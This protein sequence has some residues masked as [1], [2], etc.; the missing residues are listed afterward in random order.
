MYT[1]SKISLCA[2][3]LILTGC[4][5]STDTAAVTP[6]PP[7]TPKAFASFVDRTAGLG[8]LSDG[9]MSF[10]DATGKFEFAIGRATTFFIGT[11]DKR[12]ELG[13]AV[14]AADATADTIITPRNFQGAQEDATYNVLRLIQTLD[15]DQNLRNGI[16]LD[17]ST[18]AAFAGAFPATTVLNVALSGLEFQNQAA[19]KAALLAVNRTL[20]SQEQAQANFSL[21][22][23][24]SR[25]ASLALTSDDRKLLVVNRQKGT[26]SVIEVR[27][28]AGAD[29]QTLLG[30]VSVG[31]E[32][33][34]VAVAP[35]NSRAYVSSSINGTLT[36]IDLR[37]AVPV[38]LGTPIDVGL[39][40]R[41]IAISPTGRYAVIANS[42]L[43]SV[44]LVDLAT[45]TVVQRIITGGNPH[46]VSITNDGDSDDSD[47]TVYVS[48]LYS[49]V[50]D[51]ARP[52]GFDDAKQG[53]VDVFGLGAAVSGNWRVRQLILKPM[54][55]GF[56]ADRRN[57]CLLTR[58]ALAAAGTVKYFNSGADGLGAGANALAKTT[59]CP[60]NNSNDISA[61]GP[62]GTVPQKV[63]PNM[64]NALLVR[65]PLLYVPNVGA[66]PEPPV[67]FNVNVHG[68]VGVLD[69]LSGSETGSLN[70]NNQIKND[71]QPA[72]GVESL[73]RVFMNDLVAAD[74]DAR[75][76]NFLFVSR[77]ANYVL[78]AKRDDAG[79]LSIGAPN[80]VRLQ[81]GN[82]PTGVVMTKDSKR[83]Y[84][85]NE[86]STS[87]S[88]FDLTTNATLA[89]D[90]NSSTPPAPGTPEHFNLMGKLTFFT[91]L[92]LPD[93]GLRST[94]LRDVVPVRNKGKASDN[95]WSS[96]S[97]CHEDGH[98]DNVTWIFPTGP[99]STIALEGSFARGNPN[100]QRV[101]NWS[102][103]QGSFTD[104][105]NNARGI[106][107][108][109]GF[110]TNVGGVDNSAKAFN[111]G[112]VTGVSDSLDA[113]QTWASTIRAPQ[114]PDPTNTAGR[115]VFQASC[116][117]CHGGVKWTK[118]QILYRNNASF[119]A[120]PIGTQFFTAATTNPPLDSNLIVAGPQMKQLNAQ[121]GVA[122]LLYLDNVGTFNAADA[123]QIRGAGAVGGQVAQGFAPFGA[124]GFNTPSLL[125]FA[126]SGPWLHDGSA[127]T[128]EEVF[129]KH[130]LADGRTIEAT[131]LDPAN[132]ESLKQFVLSIDDQTPIMESDA[133]RFVRQ[134]QN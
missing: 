5:S 17:A 7:P 99:R 95:G 106:Q 92:G 41:G 97:S 71:V 83:A 91:A 98:S 14:L 108:G 77:G 82:L 133:D 129:A 117:G 38:V 115:E 8:I 42:T 73:A 3:A 36:A 44:A 18:R 126:F 85:N 110:A 89:L 102:G 9:A 72:D 78:R 121:A 104:F 22:F 56:A 131:V 120:D 87:V 28:A 12:I 65:G 13:N 68:L 53:V 23:V 101:F 123:L 50:I 118:S 128:V 76:E 66:S 40:P 34:F 127:E 80:T 25:S 32:P 16:E 59:F 54:A 96:C 45:F 39:E 122:P 63:Y 124:A 4:S 55:S 113:M 15:R 46:A 49:E 111:H 88:A 130:K 100:N 69:R 103:V 58:Q 24:Q 134:R 10:T 35:D 105:N 29:T 64:L 43:G 86:L 51:V 26:A 107:G 21:N 11:T 114:M 60:D 52:D 62:I 132:R 6:P 57:F 33:R 81:T 48:R 1:I 2:L 90:I 109:K 30:E 37:P 19:L 70:L 112:F 74:A 47:E 84:T 116:A 119:A 20:I 31:R 27:N 67:R 94:A 61:T 93:S 79:L 125:G 75:G